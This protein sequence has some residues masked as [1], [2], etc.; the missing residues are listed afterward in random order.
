M[1]DGFGERYGRAYGAQRRTDPRIASQVHAALGSAQTILN[2]GAGTGSYEPVDRQVLAVEPS[3][4]M[5]S[6]RPSERVR[7]IN[8]VA[9]ALPLDDEVVDASMALFTIHQW[10][11]PEQG[12]RELRRVSRG[13]VV[14]LTFDGEALDE[15][16]L[17]DYVPDLITFARKRYPAIDTIQSILGGTST[18]EP[19]P[20]PRDCLDGF[21]ESFYGRPERFLDPAVRQAQSAWR[22]VAQADEEKAVARLRDDLTSGAWDQRYGKLREFHQYEG[23]LRLIVSRRT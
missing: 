21:A 5:R 20:I 17:G 15:F 3:P 16:W 12:L 10:L 13:P 8:A 1:A 7:A 23:A 4:I 11:D 9:E 14:V 6:Q 22:Y 19:V 2:V 18:V